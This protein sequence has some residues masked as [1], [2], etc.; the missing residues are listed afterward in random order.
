MES[1]GVAWV[2]LGEGLLC[3][4][5]CT[6]EWDLRKMEFERKTDDFTTIVYYMT[7]LSILVLI[8]EDL[9]EGVA[10]EWRLDLLDWA[11]ILRLMYIMIWYHQ[12]DRLIGE[13]ALASCLISSSQWCCD[14]VNQCSQGSMLFPSQVVLS[15]ARLSHLL[16]PEPAPFRNNL[17]QIMNYIGI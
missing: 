10:F 4:N 6:N 7:I 3:C 9:R 16:T 11:T 8:L 15:N 1:S 14:W 5:K 12:I 2:D 13:R 17:N